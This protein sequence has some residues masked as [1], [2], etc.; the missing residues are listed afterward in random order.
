MFQKLLL[1]SFLHG[2]LMSGSIPTSASRAC[3]KYIQSHC[4]FPPT[5]SSSEFSHMAFPFR[6]HSSLDSLGLTER[7]WCTVN[8]QQ[9]S[10]FAWEIKGYLPA[11][12]SGLQQW[13][14]RTWLNKDQGILHWKPASS[15]GSSFEGSSLELGRDHHC[16][17]F[18][19]QC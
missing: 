1:L 14:C 12:F 7:L 19:V 18:K 13:P 17:F 10:M 16:W 11:G 4:L 6:S 15:E 9:W 8:S 2:A 5:E 3:G